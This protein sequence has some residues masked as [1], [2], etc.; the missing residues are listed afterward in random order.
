[1][2]KS[3]A[4]IPTRKGETLKGWFNYNKVLGRKKAAAVF[5]AS[6]APSY[7]ER[8]KKILKLD[9]QGVP[10]VETTIKTPTMKKFLSEQE[11]IEAFEKAY[12]FHTVNNTEENFRM[13][14]SEA[15]N[16]NT[17]EEDYIAYVDKV[18]G[19]IRVTVHKKN[20]ASLKTFNN[21]YGCMVLNDRLSDIFKPLGITPSMLSEAERIGNT[22]ITDFSKAKQIGGQFRDLIRIAQGMEGQIAMSEEFSHL[23][24]RALINTPLIQRLLDAYIQDIDAMREILGSDYD[25]YIKEYTDDNGEIDYESIAEEC[26]GRKLQESLLNNL[27][28]KPKTFIE[29]LVERVKKFIHS[30][31]K[32]LNSVEVDNAVI[33]AD[34]TIDDLA[35]S[36]LSRET[37][38]TT[39][40]IESTYISGNESRQSKAIMHRMV[41]NIESLDTTINDCIINETKKTAIFKNEELLNQVKIREAALKAIQT[42][43]PEGKLKGLINYAKSAIKDLR[44]TEYAL[45]NASMQ[46]RNVFALLLSARMTMQSYNGFIRQLGELVR[47]DNQ[48]LRELISQTAIENPDQTIDT[49]NSVFEGL[50]NLNAHI[51]GRF[52][53]LALDSFENFISPFFGD[54][55]FTDS[56]GKQQTLREALEEANGDINFIDRWLQTA[57]TS[58][59]IIIQMF[60]YIIQRA[61]NNARFSTIDDI[62]EIAKLQEEATKAGITDF[63]YFFEKV[64]GHKTGNYI[65]ETN[66]GKFKQEYNEMIEATNKEFGE[67]PKGRQSVLKKE[68]RRKWIL[69]HSKSLVQADEPKEGLYHNPEYDKLTEK[70]KEILNKYKALKKKYDTRYPKNRTNTIQAI[71]RRKTKVER[72]AELIGKPENIFENIKESFKQDFVSVADDDQVYGQRTGLVDF[73]GHEHMVL[74]VLYSRRLNNPDDLSTDVFGSLSAYSYASNVYYELDKVVDP[75]EVGRTIVRES[76]RVTS[77]KNDKPVVEK[78]G[79]KAQIINKIFQTGG[80]YI[81]AKLDDLMESQVYLRYYKDSDTVIKVGKTNVKTNKLLNQFLSIS[82]VA[83]LGL[84]FCANAANVATG[85]AMQNIEAAAGQFFNAKELASADAIYLKE[86]MSFLPE[87]E[88]LNKSSKLSLFDQ[89]FNIKQDFKDKAGRSRVNSFLKRMFGETV[90]FLGQTCGDHWLYNRTA[91]AMALRTKVIVDGKEM[92]LWEALKVEGEGVSKKLVLPKGAK[93]AKTG[94]ALDRAWCSDWSEAVKIVNHRL[95]GV[96]N[97]EDMVAA[98]RIAGGRM[99]LQFRKWIVPQM[100]A[101]FDS[102]KYILVLDTY[103]EGYYRTLLNFAIGLRVGQDNIMKQWEDLEDWQKANIRRCLAEITQFAAVYLLGSFLVGKAKDPESLWNNKYLEYMFQRE[104]HELGNLTPSLTMGREILK[105]VQSPVAAISSAQSILNVIGSIIDPRDWNNELQSGN[106]QGHSTLYKHIMKAPLPILPQVRQV[107]RFLNDIDDATLYYTRSF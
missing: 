28:T 92:S 16:F 49:I 7:I 76:R 2:A 105:T 31:V 91:I 47:A 74:P 38:L 40:D 6:V 87:L 3:C 82:S 9:E 80:S 37:E 58:G 12:N 66:H 65:S 88:S 84:N 5:D 86:L 32:N 106:Y 30:L 107:D 70:Q 46:D 26:V 15:K 56:H 52:E 39:G 79:K 19:G 60:N 98:E 45:M 99:L 81:E 102:K 77:I 51:K 101:R 36:I 4:Y 54:T 44:Q 55:L 10:T 67:H 104:I 50:N 35:K 8:N 103:T 71:Q 43:T 85:V 53:T 33:N 83:Q 17:Q 68:A 23:I 95:F 42:Q 78:L 18:D 89:M 25:N 94:R 61:K 13:L 63:E 97:T 34:Q 27:D 64:D 11:R 48:E 24:V 59:D 14:L 22:G 93:D 20:D 75:L 96:Y 90:A 57:S 72:R 69:A 41:T 62:E 1:M 100:A 73:S 29:R 21:Q